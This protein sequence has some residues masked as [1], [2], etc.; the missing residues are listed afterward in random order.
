MALKARSLT[1]EKTRKFHLWLVISRTQGAKVAARAAAAAAAAAAAGA[2]ASAHRLRKPGFVT[3]LR[4][5]NL[6]LPPVVNTRGNKIFQKH[7]WLP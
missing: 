6:W 4:W 2:A 3:S 7:P 5:Q 1:V